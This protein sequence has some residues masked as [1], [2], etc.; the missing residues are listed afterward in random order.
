MPGSLVCHRRA[1]CHNPP[2]PSFS[3]SLANF[4]VRCKRI[5]DI[6]L[7][8]RLAALV[9]VLR[10]A[11]IDI[12]IEWKE[13]I[14]FSILWGSDNFSTSASCQVW[15]SSYN[16]RRFHNIRHF[17]GVFGY[18]Y[19][20][21]SS[22]ESKVNLSACTFQLNP[23]AYIGISFCRASPNPLP[24]CPTHQHTDS[25]PSTH[26]PLTDSWLHTS[27]LII[28]VLTMQLPAYYGRQLG[29]IPKTLPSGVSK[30]AIINV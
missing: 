22:N 11:V 3:Q 21:P 30:F 13:L 12:S 4:G 18:K 24:S 23:I 26:W 10:K 2:I 27:T 7:H 19:E 28:V 25:H 16:A 15:I 9:N 14:A 5:S 29:C 1:V 8:L 20:Q 6:Q 17:N